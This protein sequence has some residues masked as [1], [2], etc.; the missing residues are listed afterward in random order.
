MYGPRVALW[1]VGVGSFV[2]LMLPLLT[3]WAIG[4]PP[5]PVVCLLFALVVVC[6]A[7]AEFLARRHKERQD[8][9]W[10]EGNFAS[11]EEFRG[12]VDC[13]AVLR[14][15]ETRGVGRALLEVRRQY[16]SVPLKVAARLVREL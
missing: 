12:S 14:I 3:D 6:P 16:P 5:I 11:F 2:W 15:R 7:T 13:A 9:A 10:Y 4:L 1:A 8:Q